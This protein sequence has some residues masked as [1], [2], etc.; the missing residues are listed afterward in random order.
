MN[1]LYAK[2][3]KKYSAERLRFLYADLLRCIDVDGEDLCPRGMEKKARS[4]RNL[5]SSNFALPRY[6]KRSSSIGEIDDDE[7]TAFKKLELAAVFRLTTA[8]RSA[9][10]EVGVADKFDARVDASVRAQTLARQLEARVVDVIREIGEVVV[11][12]E[13]PAENE[14]LRDD[15]VFAYFC[16]KAILA[17]LV[18]IMKDTPGATT[19]KK[20]CFH[21][22]VWSP[23]VKGQVLQTVSLLVS[24]VR[25]MTALYYILS[26]HCVNQLILCMLPLTQWTDPALEVMLPAYTDLLK[27]LSL[28][29]GGSPDLFPFFT[30][31][32]NETAVMFPL[33]SAIVHIATSSYAQSDSYVHGTCLNLIVGLMRISD[34]HIRS[35]IC[36]AEREQ[37]QLCGHLCRQLHEQHR[38]IANSTI[39]PV[40][41]TVR[42]S[43][44]GAQLSALDDQID[45][46]NDVLLCNINVLNVRLCEALLQQF[47]RHLLRDLLPGN[48][49]TFLQVGVS[50]SDVIPTREA[51]AQ[52]ASFTLSRTLANLEFGPLLRMLAVA[53]FH[54]KS[55]AVWESTGEKEYV[56]MP[57]LNA[58]IQ[59]DNAVT[60]MN[61]YKEEIFR[62]LSG[63]YG[64]WR[65]VTA[66]NL[67]ENAIL[68]VDKETLGMLRIFPTN[69]GGEGAESALEGP[70]ASF[71]RRKHVCKSSVSAMSLECA[72]SLATQYLFRLA[73]KEKELDKPSNAL[74]ESSVLAAL[75]SAQTYFYEKTVE[76]QRS[77]PANDIVVDLVEGVIKTRYRR[78]ST[79]SLSTTAKFVQKTHVFAYQLSQHG[80]NS[81]CS[82]SEPLTRKLRGVDLNNVEVTRFYATMAVHFRAVR[83]VV[84][85]F[86]SYLP[87]SMAPELEFVDEAGE[88]SLMFGCLRDKP[89]I[90]TVIDLHGRMT[91]AFSVQAS[92]PNDALEQHRGAFFRE[93]N[94]FIVVLDPTDLFVVKPFARNEGKR[95]TILCSIPLLDVVAAAA[96]ETRLHV[97]VR[98]DNVG[99]LIKNGNLV[100]TFESAG[101]CLLVARYLDRCRILLRQELYGKIVK[102]FSCVAPIHTAVPSDSGGADEHVETM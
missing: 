99:F 66:A 91:F 93:S 29:L 38:R 102:Y 10:K 87:N 61:I 31:Q 84:D 89:H 82:S 34:D 97:A 57:A 49:R 76:S 16:E 33:F 52:A 30:F 92:E 35:W 64:E 26:Q 78:H 86:H 7:R 88:L 94:H 63:E 53:L 9:N 96:D 44:I 17:V 101:T 18:E 14:N 56:V 50:D 98:H 85:R 54:P 20:S 37:R 90:G 70:L 74:H 65:V 60:F 77:I 72:S 73:T 4:G 75:R 40:V 12:A 69:S 100:L 8:T 27:T 39:G 71:L 15:D 19:E 24:G 80:S 13:R 2:P 59:D 25:D 28:Q 43:S 6:L 95:G 46:V 51:A 32:S 5:W 41:D 21:G 42:S 58:L 1:L 36:R 81:H 23:N 45:A 79:T 3:R 62:A 83:R 47:V 55:S 48:N 11:N 68:A 67:V 22:V